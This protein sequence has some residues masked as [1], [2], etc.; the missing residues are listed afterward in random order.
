MR[1]FYGVVFIS[2]EADVSVEQDGKD[3]I[4]EGVEKMCPEYHGVVDPSHIVP[5]D[6][7]VS[8]TTCEGMATNEIMSHYIITNFRA[9][10]M[11]SFQVK[12]NKQRQNVL[13]H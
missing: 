12:N 11:T 3:R 6:V 7:Q 1:V 13:F 2:N 8:L 9:D 5:F 4:G 10:P